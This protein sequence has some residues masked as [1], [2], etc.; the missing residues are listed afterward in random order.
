[1]CLSRLRIRSIYSKTLKTNGT[2]T[3]ALGRDKRERHDLRVSGAQTLSPRSRQ[4]FRA[5]QLSSR[6][7]RPSELDRGLGREM[8]R[9]AVEPVRELHEEPLPEEARLHVVRQSSERHDEDRDLGES[10]RGCARDSFLGL[11]LLETNF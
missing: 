10:P 2:A 11:D 5:V 9:R 1:M 4:A 6:V 3:D 8:C 7:R